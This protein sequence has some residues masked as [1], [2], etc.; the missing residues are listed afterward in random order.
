MSVLIVVFSVVDLQ[1]DG[2]STIE[3]AAYLLYPRSRGAIG[4]DR[5]CRS[6]L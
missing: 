5:I 6:G 2:L 4:R 1:L 3:H